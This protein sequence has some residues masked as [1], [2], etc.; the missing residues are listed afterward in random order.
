MANL[1]PFI[2]GAS[3]IDPEAVDAVGSLAQMILTLTGANILDGIA[4][5]ITGKTSL[6]RFG[7][8]LVPFGEAMA[9]FSDT[10]KGRID[11]ESVSAASNAGLALAQMAATIPKQGGVLQNI[12]GSQDLSAFSSQLKI[13]GEAIASFSATVTGKI[14]ANAVTAASNAG[15]TLSELANK[16]PKQGGVLQD[17]LGS[18]DLGVF[19]SQL[20]TFGEA[21]A[22]FSQTV[23][24]KIDPEIVTSAANAAMSLSE[25]AN[26]LPK[27]G[28]VLQNIFGE[29]DLGTFGSQLKTFGEAIVGFSEE[30]KGK[31]DPETATAAASAGA[32]LADLAN[33][34]PK[35]GGIFQNFFGDQD[36]G[37]FG[38]QLASFGKSFGEYADYVKNV[39]PGVVSS[40][41]NAANSLVT[42]AESLPDNKLF[43]NE[44]T[45]DEF[46]SQ[47]SEFGSYFN[48]YYT[49]VSG[50][51]T[52]KLSAVVDEVRNLLS[53]GNSMA[54]FN[55]KAMSNFADSLTDLGN[56]GVDGFI[57]AFTNA[58]GRVQSAADGMLSAFINSANTRRMDFSS[59][60][61]SLITNVLTFMNNKQ[62]EFKTA[63]LNFMNKLLE[64]MDSKKKDFNSSMTK[65]LNDIVSE[66]RGKYDAFRSAGV[67]LVSGF[68]NGLT[69]NNAAINAA[70]R[71]AN[72]TIE[73][74]QSELKIKSPS[75]VAR[76]EVGKWIVEGVSEGITEDMSAEEAASKKAQN[77]TSAFQDELSM[78]DLAEE[79]AKL[80]AELQGT[81]LDYLVQHEQQVKRVELAYGE[82]QVMLEEVG[83]TATETQEAYNKYLQ[84]EIEL[85]DL[86]N[87]KA[88]ENY[89][90]TIDWIEKVKETNSMSI[91]E[92][93]TLY[94][95]LQAVY[96]AGSEQRLAIDQ[97]ILDLQEQLRDA[98]EEYYDSLNDLE[99]SSNEKRLQLD[100]DYEDERTQIKEDANEQ[101]LQ[102]D[103]E[104]ANKTKEIN[105]QL[106]ADIEAAEKK[107]E[108][109]L[110]SRTDSLYDSYGLFDKVEPKEEEVTGDQLIENLESQLSAFQNWTNNLNSLI[111]R[112]LDEALI[113]ELR[114]M[115]PSSA[116][117][118]EALASMT[119]EELN[120]YVELWKTKHQLAADQA[121]SELE[122]MREETN[123]T[124]EKLKEDAEKELDEY[125]ETWREQVQALND[126]TDDKLRELRRNWLNNI[127]ELDQETQE[128]L[129]ELRSNWMES[130]MGLQ[131]ETESAFTKMTLA[132][133]ERMGNQNQWSTAGA[134]MIQGVLTGIVMNTPALVEGVEDAMQE[135]LDAANRKLGIHS[136]S[137]E[138]AKVGRYSSEGF[139]VGLKKY[140]GLISDAASN[141][142]DSAIES[143][144]GVISR[145]SSLVTDDLDTEPTIRPVLDLS[146][147][148]SGAMRLNTMFSRNQALAIGATVKRAEIEE[149]QNGPEAP[150]SGNVYQFTQNNYS[151][152]ALSR[153][154][155]YRQTKNQFSAM[156][157][158]VET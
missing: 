58:T 45:L 121:T 117:E 83:A 16:I 153:V 3:Q 74:M 34:L 92:E 1:Q 91:I 78:L 55:S 81:G 6:E 147:I 93:M 41:A 48:E 157:R 18:Q 25:L 31:V 37:T 43:V 11:S 142:G 135:A 125:R 136:P 38:E 101:R 67:Y 110:K 12:F 47:L 46:G 39:E 115:G 87:E 145:I 151:P 14:D 75:R 106:Q 17:F 139:V 54:N 82:Y 30:V 109:A 104:Y 123:E 77:I 76:D 122:G 94:K 65:L 130:V 63:G 53:L 118:I 95:R 13:F 85:R 158:M 154:D 80:E 7:E 28:G 79:T 143:L 70:R 107:Y 134:N 149:V 29:Q 124:I 140:S 126:E 19:G 44:T 10:I 155:I 88:A 69:S 96:A 59:T 97:K 4:S 32:A 137:K 84:E 152:K 49:S 111:G 144:R 60:F 120:K 127:D 99:Q 33:K 50:I 61:E 89:Q 148:E 102:L 42:L 116:A 51:N 9:E 113:E 62:P 21:I 90:T 119:D 5:F 57:S 20:K 23:T 66:M 156:E 27:Q 114:E 15:L 73:T 68:A 150:K 36:I 108:D 71:L 103:Q 64:G 56:A 35:Q 8:Q 52:Q 105:D 132:L 40:T 141:L 112:G 2:A 22:A 129:E 133:V 98:T 131:E 138:F 128:S 146:S 24:G 72:K 100:Q 86:A 26:K